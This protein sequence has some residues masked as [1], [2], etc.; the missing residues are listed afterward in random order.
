MPT[1]NHQGKIV[2][3]KTKDIIMTA[4]VQMLQAGVLRRQNLIAQGSLSEAEL[5]LLRHEADKMMQIVKA[6]NARLDPFTCEWNLTLT[7]MV[8]QKAFW[9]AES[10]TWMAKR[11]EG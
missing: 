9:L 1:L 7:S 10:S 11:L 6:C 8:G 4:A 5:E 2:S 3:T